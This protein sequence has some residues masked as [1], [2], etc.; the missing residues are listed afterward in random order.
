MATKIRKSGGALYGYCEVRL[1]GCTGLENSPLGVVYAEPNDR[2][3]NV[4]NN[5]LEA[6]LKSGDWSEA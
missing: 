5:C 4:C 3:V 1:E 6:K 2:Q